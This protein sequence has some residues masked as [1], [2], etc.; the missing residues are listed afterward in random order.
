MNNPKQAAAQMLGMQ[1]NYDLPAGDL[2]LTDKQIISFGSHS[3]KVMHTPGHSGGSVCFYCAEE[4]VIFT[5]DTL[6]K[7]SIGRTDFPGG[8]MFQIISTTSRHYYC[9]SWAWTTDIYR[10]RAIS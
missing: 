2:K 8:S 10:F 5:G 3:F 7:G 6:F 9:L 1:L 4:N